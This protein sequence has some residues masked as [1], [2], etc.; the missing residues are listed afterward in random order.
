MRG[1]RQV[2][3]SLWPASRVQKGPRARVDRS[4]PPHAPSASWHPAAPAARV[5]R[6]RPAFAAV[7]DGL[8]GPRRVVQGVGQGEAVRGEQGF[9]VPRLPRHVRHLLR[10]GEPGEGGALEAP[11]G[12][13]SGRESLR[14]GRRALDGHGGTGVPIHRKRHVSSSPR[15]DRCGRLTGG[16]LSGREIPMAELGRCGSDFSPPPRRDISS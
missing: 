2:A 13:W 3:R 6:S 12:Y 9:H 4:T 16:T 10:A 8:S 7:L 1:A 15:R 5:T 14:D 11:R